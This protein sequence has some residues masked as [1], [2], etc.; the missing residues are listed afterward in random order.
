MSVNGINSV[1]KYKSKIVACEVLINKIKYTI[2]AMCL[3]K[4]DIFLKVP[5]LGKIVEEFLSKGYTLAN[6]FLNSDSKTISNIQFIFGI[7]DRYC[8]ISGL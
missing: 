5:M 4:I 6:T 8:L 1:K 7:K 3:P 2:T